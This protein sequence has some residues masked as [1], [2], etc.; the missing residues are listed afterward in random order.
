MCNEGRKSKFFQYKTFSFNHRVIF[1]FIIQPMIS[2][3]FFKCEDGGNH[4]ALVVQRDGLWVQWT[5]SQYLRDI[6]TAAKA[7]IR[8]GLEPHHGKKVYNIVISVN[9]I[10]LLLWSYFKGYVC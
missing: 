10:N 2:K 3:Y 1:I 7:F 4:V 8:L 9:I 6:R 5:Y